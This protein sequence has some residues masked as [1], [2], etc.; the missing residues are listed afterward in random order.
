MSN[1]DDNDSR[2]E[3]SIE[4]VDDQATSGASQPDASDREPSRPLG[5]TSSSEWIEE[6]AP[7]GFVRVY[8]QR[9]VDALQERGRNHQDQ[10]IVRRNS[11][12]AK[13]LRRYRGL[14]ELGGAEEFAAALATVR[15]QHPHFGEVIDLY[16]RRH[17]LAKQTNGVALF[18]PVLLY[19]EPGLGKTTF[20]QS[21]AEVFRV[22]HRRISYDGEVTNAALLGLDKKWGNS[23]HGV[24]FE[25]VCL[26]GTANPVVILDEI[27]KAHRSQN[28]DALS[29][30]H[31]VLEP[32]TARHVRD[33]SLDF[34]FDASYVTYI[35]TANA[36]RLIPTSI[37]S[38]FV[39]FWIA[40]P[41]ARDSIQLALELV[42][43]T[44]N[45]VAP[46]DFQQPA[47]DI[48]VAIAHCTAREMRAALTTAIANAV[49]DR[50][51]YLLLSDL[52][53]SVVGEA[54]GG[55]RK[56]LH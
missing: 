24:L 38:R 4:A 14:A 39:E 53:A 44:V 47:R 23:T 1:I 8:S 29:A 30:L 5:R 55:P 19:G 20:A 15:K 46:T 37:R 27:D 40:F 48:A 12:L 34:E 41:S 28:D 36:A 6:T 9:E 18:P 31:S 25:L 13:T 32:A 10:D 2:R 26:E 11:L 16:E 42:R 50:R 33:V 43:K 52:P 17:A 49:H 56:W 51:G 45:E 3:A 21:V 54:Q 22:Q 7:A 35:A